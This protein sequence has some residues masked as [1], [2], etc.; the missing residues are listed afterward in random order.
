MNHRR[1]LLELSL[2]CLLLVS[3]CLG[4]E[5]EDTASA[6]SKRVP[7]GA[8]TLPSVSGDHYSE[9]LSDGT[10]KFAYTGEHRYVAE[11]RLSDGTI[12]GESLFVRP[13]GVPVKVHYFA[14]K[15]GYRPKTEV[16]YKERI[17]ATH[18]PGVIREVVVPSGREVVRTVGRV[19]EV[20]VPARGPPP[21]PVIVAPPSGQNSVNV[22]LG[23]ASFRSAGHGGGDINV[24]ARG[25]DVAISSPS[26][27][28]IVGPGGHA[29]VRPEAFAR[30][31]GN[32]NKLFRSS[33][34]DSGDVSIANPHV[35]AIVGA[36]GSVV[37]E[38]RASAVTGGHPEIR[39]VH[40]HTQS[41]VQSPPVVQRVVER[42]PVAVPV[43][44]E[45]RRGYVYDAPRPASTVVIP[46]P[47]RAVAVPVHQ[48]TLIVPPSSSYSYSYGYNAPDPKH[49]QR[50]NS[51]YVNV[52]VNQ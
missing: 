16:L 15:E 17:V 19:H 37:V 31:S 3:P 32:G 47:P 45:T 28:A 41:V 34:F 14:D 29:V 18:R 5:E 38:P 46:H 39:E 9:V 21:P 10:Y 2:A 52:Q 35:N 48:Q 49:P 42:I 22:N 4:E 36:G 50:D 11:R 25:G 6:D 8:R 24:N 20:V 27:T 51:A 23:A 33:G 30:T 12:E 44:V 1:F 43:P 26:V 13:D 7:R 40:H